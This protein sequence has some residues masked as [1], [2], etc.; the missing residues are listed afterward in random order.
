MAPAAAVV[1]VA[2]AAAVAFPEVQV[3]QGA[4]EAV[5]GAE[6]VVAVAVPA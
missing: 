6:A 2:E 5:G 4:A 3:G 1:V